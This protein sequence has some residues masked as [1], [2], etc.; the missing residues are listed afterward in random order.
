M[1]HSVDKRRQNFHEKPSRSEDRERAGA[2]SD[3]PPNSRLFIVCGK[4]ITE[5]E[6]QE[7][8]QM[9]GTIEEVWVLKERGI[10]YIKF[11][12][13]S[14]AALAME[15]MNGRCLP[16]HP[17]P[18]KVMIANT[19]S[20]GSSRD[21][22]ETERCR[23]FL[24]VP[25]SMTEDELKKH[26]SEFGD[27]DYV[28]VVKDRST[29]ENKG[30]AYVK[31]HR[32]SHASR[33]FEECDRSFKPVFAEPK[34][35]KVS[36][37]YH[38]GGGG[39][40]SGGQTGPGST[41]SGSSVSA[42]DMLSYMDASTTNPEGICCLSVAAASTV[43]Q[44]Q[45]WR[46]FDIVPGLDYCELKQSNPRGGGQSRGIPGKNMFVV[47]YNNPQSSAYAKEKLHG[48]EYPPGQRLT[49][50]FDNYGESYGARQPMRQS[51]GPPLPM[52]PPQQQQQQ[53]PSPAKSNYDLAHLSETIANATALLQAAGYNAGGPT[54]ARTPQGAPPI[55]T[56]HAG[57]TYDPSYCSVKLPAPQP[58]AAMESP[59]AERLFFVCT[60][61]SP[62]LYT[63]KDVFSRFGH[64]IDI[65]LLNG[66]NCGYAKYSEKDSA[67]RAV[68]A[69][70]GQ[71]VSGC[72]LKV[73][74]ADP[75]DKNSDPAG[76]KRQKFDS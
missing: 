48:F 30:F 15:T 52:A 25:K 8:F 43:N 53:Y 67:D 22:N 35:N 21:V 76:R 63:L 36:S 40:G 4:N 62:P 68:S 37:T 73:M 45:I 56:V 65:Y 61:A 69:L 71:E 10:A 55:P 13:T 18:L 23:L 46:L 11:S 9:F 38:E 26:F 19:R 57:E 28:S 5:E 58:L 7:S 31:Y 33:A 66:K 14:E 51:M 6:F 72:R 12:K 2:K 70:H 60:Q 34:P 59:V 50:K 1:Q 3:N 44:D 27:V 42:Y 74:T 32:M 75:R 39:G 16:P 54:P 24:V 29:N 49:I 20:Q 64:L 41:I 17:R 47:V